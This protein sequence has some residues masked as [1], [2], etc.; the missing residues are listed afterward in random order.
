[1]YNWTCL[2]ELKSNFKILNS[3]KEKLVTFNRNSVKVHFI[4]ECLLKYCDFPQMITIII[5]EKS[6][7]LKHNKE[8]LPIFQ[9]IT[10]LQ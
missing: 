7:T 5:L 9:F 4:S 10:A 2:L 3:K 8:I 1:M 6:H